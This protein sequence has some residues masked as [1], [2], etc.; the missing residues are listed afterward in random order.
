MCAA[1]LVL[2]CGEGRPPPAGSSDGGNDAATSADAAPA[3]TVGS[4]GCLQCPGFTP[5]PLSLS[6]PFRGQR[7]SEWVLRNYFDLDSTPDA[8]EDYVGTTGSRAH[9]YDGH[10]GLD[11]GI[12]N[13]RTMDAGV[14]LYAAAS[15]RV[16]RSVDGRADRNTSLSDCG[17]GANFVEV[18]HPSG[19]LLRYFHFKKDTVAV[20][21]GEQVQAGSYLGDVGSSG[22]STWPHLHFELRDCEGTSLET[23]LTEYWND[24]PA[25]TANAGVLDVVTRTTHF[26]SGSVL[27]QF[28]D[29]A[30]NPTSFAAGSPLGFGLIIGE[31]VDG[32]AIEVTV[33]DGAGAVFDTFRTTFARNY[34]RS[35]W[36]WNRTL[37]GAAGDWQAT[38]RINGSV[39][40]TESWSVTP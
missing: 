2:G 34:S 10:R 38:V 5:A 40:R 27:E 28:R 15:G 24:K 30:A 29:A 9:T 21:E 23:F 18:Q 37:S 13:F 14:P 6:W 7:S 3:C 22:C 31:G 36:Y 8:L 26:E 11:I 25:Y 17:E 35:F 19:Y 12:A 1:A 33:S 32:D 4:A 16:V 20:T 39:Q